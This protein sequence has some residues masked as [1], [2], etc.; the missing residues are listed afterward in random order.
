MKKTV[1]RHKQARYSKGFT[2][3]ELMVTIVI[4]GTLSTLGISTF[5]S[6]QSKSRDIKRKS[7]LAE[8]ST[9]LEYYANDAGTYPSSSPDGKILACGGTCEWGSPFVSSV[10]AKTVYMQSLPKDTKPGSSYRYEKTG[11]GYM[12]YAY[13]ETEFDPDRDTNIAVSCGEHM[14]NYVLR[15]TNLTPTPMP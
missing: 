14:C 4:L 13:L 12:L 2:L 5:R 9:S 1:Y 10:N 6:S 8:V 3:I 15:S 11:K 7:D